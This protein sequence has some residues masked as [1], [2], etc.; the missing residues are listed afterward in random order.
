MVK[1]PR[2][3]FTLACQAEKTLE[4]VWQKFKHTNLRMTSDSIQGSIEKR[5]RSKKWGSQAW[6]S[7]IFWWPKAVAA[8]WLWPTI[9]AQPH[10]TLILQHQRVQEKRKEQIMLSWSL[11]TST[12]ALICWSDFLCQR[13]NLGYYKL[14]VTWRQEGCKPVGWPP[15]LWGGL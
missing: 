5:K 13:G 4:R 2:H 14:H 3:G 11:L 9:K 6:L 7:Y 10:T 8:Q 1:K 15:V 12:L